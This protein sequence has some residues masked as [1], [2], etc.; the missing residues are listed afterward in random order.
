M[1]DYFGL[2]HSIWNASFCCRGDHPKQGFGKR[3]PSPTSK[4]A[5]M[6]SDFKLAQKD[7]TQTAYFTTGS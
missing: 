1:K 5:I 4:A 2:R 7:I 3:Q 6:H